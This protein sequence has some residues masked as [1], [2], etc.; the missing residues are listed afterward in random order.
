MNGITTLGENIADNA[1]VKSAYYAYKNWTEQNGSE[2]R[3]PGLKYNQQQLFWISFG[4]LWCSASKNYVIRNHI[5]ASDH[6]PNEFR[7]NGPISNMPEHTFARD[8]DC[9]IGTKM[10]PRHKCIVW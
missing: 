5:I 10:N 6:S 4:Q 7:V 8:F 2:A 9:S 1:G 3:L